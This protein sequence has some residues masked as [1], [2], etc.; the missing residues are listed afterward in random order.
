MLARRRLTSDSKV[1]E[2]PISDMPRR[3]FIT[4]LGSAAAAWPLDAYAQQ[5]TSRMPLIGVI[6]PAAQ[7]GAFRQGLRD[8]GYIEGQTVAFEYRSAEDKP[9]RLDE[10]AGELTHLPVDVIVAFGTAAAYAAKQATTKIPIVMLGIGDPVRSGLVTSLAQPGGNITGNTILGAELAAKRL[11]PDDGADH[12]A[13]D[14]AVADP[15]PLQDMA[16]RVVDPAV[17][18]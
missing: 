7:W 5:H 8:L 17:D 18:A 10:A 16:H 3:A 14:V 13:V 15:E 6:D 4:L 11:H 9:D 12:V 1:G 2:N